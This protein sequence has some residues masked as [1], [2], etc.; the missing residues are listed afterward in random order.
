VIAS[1]FVLLYGVP[2]EGRPVNAALPG[3]IR[4]SSINV[5][6]QPSFDAAVIAH[7]PKGNVIV[8]GRD[9]AGDFIYLED[10]GGWVNADP[11]Y[12]DLGPF[13]LSQLPVLKS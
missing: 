9:A 6:E 3:R 13:D 7:A 5:R 11:T 1:S 8:S 10:Y 2:T 4:P 12:V